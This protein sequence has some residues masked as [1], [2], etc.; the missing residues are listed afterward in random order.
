M[1][2]LLFALLFAL[3]LRALVALPTPP[4]Q[5][6]WRCGD[7]G[8]M[9]ESTNSSCRNCQYSPKPRPVTPGRRS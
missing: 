9:N 6:Q 5:P 1:R 8:A 3:L 4:R 7:C 2:G